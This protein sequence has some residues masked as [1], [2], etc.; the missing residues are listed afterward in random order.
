M[1][2]DLVQSDVT[3]LHI[4][5]CLKGMPGL[6]GGR[7]VADS[8]AADHRALHVLVRRQR[9]VIGGAQA[10]ACGMTSGAVRCRIRDGGL[11]QRRAGLAAAAAAQTD[12]VAEPGA[13]ASG[14]AAGSEIVDG[15]LTGHRP[16]GAGGRLVPGHHEGDDRNATTPPRSRPSPPNSATAP[17]N[18]SAATPPFKPS[19]SSSPTA[20][21]LQRPPESAP[22]NA[23]GLGPRSRSWRCGSCQA[24]P[25]ASHCRRLQG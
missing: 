24:R 4:H 22:A 1:N 9:Q 18:A 6:G 5:D 20:N 8:A 11:W 10:L 25:A 16:A 2:V 12:A 15:V 3:L 17:A 23:A 14:A 19:L 13:A 21:A 7:W